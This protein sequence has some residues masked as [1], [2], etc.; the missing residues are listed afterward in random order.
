MFQGANCTGKTGKMTK[1]SSLSGKTQGI[2][3]FRQNTGNFVCSSC[4]LPDS[5]ILKLFFRSW[6]CLPGQFLYVIVTN[7]VNWHREN[8][9]S[10][11]ENTGKLKMQFVWGP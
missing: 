1:T 6:N 9:R 2:W 7:H 10:D 3:K 4:K 5:K 8:L 11:R